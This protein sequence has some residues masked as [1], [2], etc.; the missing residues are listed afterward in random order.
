M[1]LNNAQSLFSQPGSITTIFVSNAGTSE[2]GVALNDQAV[3]LVS[4]AA[5]GLVVNPVKADQLE[6]AA[7]G[8][9]FITTL[10]I[11]FGTF[12]IF[13]GI[14][15]IFLIFTVLAAER[16][17]ELGMSRAVGL[18]RADL[19]RQFV[20]EGLAYNFLAAAIGAA[21]GVA[22]A[23]LLAGT[24]TQILGDSSLNI[25]PRVSPRSIAI[26]FMLG[27]VISFITVSLSAIRTS[28]VN[29][30]AAIRDL[31]LPVPERLPQWTL[32]LRPF[33]VWRAA[34]EQAGQGNG[35]E[36]LRLFLLAGPKAILNFWG[37]L[38]AR[39]P[40]LI[41]L[42]Y[43]FAWLGVNVIN[44]GVIPPT[45]NQETLDPQCDLDYVPN[46]ARPKSV[47]VAMS[48]SFAFGGQNCVLVFKRFDS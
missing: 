45:I 41:V 15:L 34:L 39:G 36:A 27:L 20:T 12:S 42:G 37:A 24:L 33:V 8:A 5:P 29:I 18:Q 47:R 7:S 28:K 4:G 31:N 1:G 2:S 48:N 40:V 6:A 17:S 13:S 14:L 46:R 21:L 19:V 11:T 32:F 10:F 23:L 25:T 43:L 3:S 38:F 26:G 22:A 9:E 30:I 44:Q 16:K 35:R